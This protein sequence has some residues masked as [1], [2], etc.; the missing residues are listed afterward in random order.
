MSRSMKRMVLLSP[1]V[2]E[3]SAKLA[4]AVRQHTFKVLPD[5]T[6]EEVMVCVEAMFDVKVESV[7]VVNMKGKRKGG[8]DRKGRRKH[9][10][11]AYVTLPEG[12]DIQFAGTE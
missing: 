4:D 8:R 5:A 11:K 1:H 9:W 7:N 6:K 3:K 10:K 12:E 2:S